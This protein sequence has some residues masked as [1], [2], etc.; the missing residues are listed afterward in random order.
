MPTSIVSRIHLI[1]IS[2]VQNNSHVPNPLPLPLPRMEKSLLAAIDAVSGNSGATDATRCY[3]FRTFSLLFAIKKNRREKKYEKYRVP[4]ASAVAYSRNRFNWL[5][6]A[7]ESK[8]ERRRTKINQCLT[9]KK[10]LQ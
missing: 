6:S 2:V 4:S 5:G 9:A 10:C 7:R 3:F 8:S 1:K